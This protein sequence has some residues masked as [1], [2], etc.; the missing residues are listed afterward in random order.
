[1]IGRAFEQDKP[2]IQTVQQLQQAIVDAWEDIPMER[3][4]H[5]VHSCHKDIWL[6]FR[7]G[8]DILDINKFAQI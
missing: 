4:Q 7:V 8:V 5:L 1:L 3:L 2:P 6:F